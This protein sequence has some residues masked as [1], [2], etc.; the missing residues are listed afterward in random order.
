ME[1]RTS[2]IDPENEAIGQV[3]CMMASRTSL[4]RRTGRRF[5][6]PSAGW[7]LRGG[8]SL[9]NDAEEPRPKVLRC[10]QCRCAI[11]P[12]ID[13]APQRGPSVLIVRSKPR[14]AGLVA[15]VIAM[16]GGALGVA[17]TVH[18][19]RSG[20]RIERNGALCSI[21][22]DAYPPSRTLLLTS[23]ADEAQACRELASRLAIDA[24]PDR[25]CAMV[26]RDTGSSCAAHAPAVEKAARR[27]VTVFG[28]APV[29]IG[30]GPK[31]L[32]AVRKTIHMFA[33]GGDAEAAS[34]MDPRSVHFARGGL[35]ECLGV[36]A[37]DK[38]LLTAAHCLQARAGDPVEEQMLVIF[39]SDDSGLSV[40]V[41]CQPAVTGV[42]WK[43]KAP[44]GCEPADP[45]QPLP[46]ACYHDIAVCRPKA[47]SLPPWPKA[48]TCVRDDAPTAPL[49]ALAWGP[50]ATFV[51][52]KVDSVDWPAASQS[53]Y[54]V[55]Q[56][57]GDFEFT[58]GDS[59]GPLYQP[60][61]A[62]AASG[63][64]TVFALLSRTGN[65]GSFVPIGRIPAS[66]RT[67]DW[68]AVKCQP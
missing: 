41:E 16:A 18:W 42:D 61:D 52:E 7:R 2:A 32:E 1:A 62:G 40:Q 59:G 19:Q 45:A 21:T 6:E 58:L 46:A 66:L 55:A 60:A 38:V 15:L 23:I 11:Q 28:P 51:T 64:P 33:H 49:K 20:F 39:P 68:P 29:A 10:P 3:I 13:N 37:D 50:W 14:S 17:G 8:C 22:R 27:L 31:L 24:P 30:H 44:D 67:A 5:D 63:A 65:R 26:D 4:H 36:V 53:A 54:V 48:S 43:A 34:A 35:R 56:M 47:G 9:R 57:P 12:P 25:A